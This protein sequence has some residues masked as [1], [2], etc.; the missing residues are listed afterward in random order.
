MED[1]SKSLQIKKLK[2]A[3]VETEGNSER[4]VSFVASTATEDRD[5]EVV[6]IE[7]F[8][9]PL[10]GGGEIVVSDLPVE[11][12]DNIDIPFLTNHDLYD[13]A[14]TI[15][16][17]RKATFVDGK[18]IFE[19]GISSRDYAQ[20]M[21]K[22][23]E[24]GH[25]DNAFSIQ[26][27]DYSHNAD[28]NAD[29]GGEI[30]EVSLVTRGSNKD[31]QVLAVKAMKSKGDDMPEEEKPQ[32][33]VETTEATVEETPI[34]DAPQKTEAEATATAEAEKTAEVETTEE[35]EVETD[36][37]KEEIKE[38]NKE[39]AMS[40][41]NQKE[42]AATQVKMPS[43]EA[44]AVVDATDYLKSKSAI[45]DYARVSKSC[46]GDA[47]MLNSAWENHLNSKGITVADGGSFL[48]TAVEQVMFK[49]WHDA[50]G[51]L[52]TFRRTRA[53]ASRFYAMTTED[54]AL[55]HKNGDDKA[56]QD[57]V[58][59]ARNAGLKV[60]YK[61]LPLPWLDIVND[62]TG[63][64]YVFRER[65][66]YDRVL[67][68]I[69]RGAIVGDGL[70]APSGSD[71]DYRVFDGTNG[72]YSIAG[73]ITASTTTGSYSATVATQVANEASDN[74]Y[75][76]IVKTLGAVRADANTAKKVLVLPEGAVTELRLL[77]NVNGGLMFPA[78][79]DL[80]SSLG[81][82]QIIELSQAD[83]TRIGMDVIAYRVDAYT[84]GGPDAT[85]RNWFD[86]NKNL[87]YQLVE[88]PVY[89]SLEGYKA[90]AGYMSA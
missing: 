90:A 50:V 28:T 84:L 63:E 65:E 77:Q 7:T 4:R 3:T 35:T 69:V 20:D 83:F 71:P 78:G 6:Q 10:K 33:I 27:R 34:E 45:K 62:D 44:T 51:A 1:K 21:F 61:K 48:P 80:A 64:L 9:L 41:L 26:Y 86:G 87:D 8:R 2:I 16:S 14:K 73:D 40:E 31:A 46:G 15:G 32:E 66:L 29:V 38:E 70:A 36:E 5:Y 18:L 49:A 37:K 67:A 13:V 23:I 22:L 11:G 68:Q 74:I 12:A 17:V 54:T 19:V 55:G 39:K 47:S 81:V 85:V 24:E 57:V 56:D 76:K 43:Q 88:Q 30:V 25:L 79:I 82:D 59:I 58:A 75:A 89:G 53:K 60:V 72:L 42:I 52:A